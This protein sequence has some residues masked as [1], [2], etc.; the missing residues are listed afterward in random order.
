MKPAGNPCNASGFSERQEEL[1]L[2]EGDIH[3]PMVMT[4]FIQI[5]YELS[6][7]GDRLR[8]QLG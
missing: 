7:Q 6:M 5:D 1:E 3:I 2:T 4:D 8:P